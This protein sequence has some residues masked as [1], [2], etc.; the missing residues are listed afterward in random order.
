LNTQKE[1]N[2]LDI[3]QRQQMDPP[4]SREASSGAF[5]VDL[6]LYL[7]LMFL[8]REVYFPSLGFI[9]NGLFWS[10]TTLAFATWRMRARGITWADLGLCRPKNIKTAVI[11]T[12]FILGMA[13]AFIVAFEIIN[14]QFQSGIAPDTSNESAA[15]KFGTLKGS[16]ALF[17]AITPLI[18]LESFLEEVGMHGR[19]LRASG[20][21][22]DLGS[23]G[24]SRKQRGR[25]E[26][27]SGRG[28]S[29]A[30]LLVVTFENGRAHRASL[31]PPLVAPRVRAWNGRLAL[32]CGM[33]PG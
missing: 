21:Q 8:I 5:F 28:H 13:I 20:T 18:W 7:P 30:L 6:V 3:T 11:A 12:L 23:D 29:R 16:W 26:C 22:G 9:F 19:F 1:V 17:F 10:L 27:G 15:Q 25:T 2:R 32:L 31:A 4:R 14:E 33:E 24:A